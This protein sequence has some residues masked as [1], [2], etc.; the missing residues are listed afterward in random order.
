[1]AGNLSLTREYGR[2]FTIMRDE[3]IDP[4]LWDNVSTRTALL[5]CMKAKGAIIETG[6]R[7]QLAFK[8]LKELPTSVGYSDLETITPVR[9]DPWTQARYLWKQIACPVQVSGLDM[10]QTGEG[11]ESD[12]LE[13]FIQ[14]AEISMRESI[15]GS[16]I[17]IFSSIGDTTLTGISGLQSHFTTSTTTGTVGQLSRAS[18]SNWR[19]QLQNV[20]SAFDSN[21]INLMTQLYYEC[22]RFDETPDIFVV[23]KSTWLNFMRETTR[24][25][26]TNFPMMIGE[27]DKMMI[28][29]GFPNTRHFGALLFG[30][31]GCLANT[32]YCFNTKFVKLYVRSGRNAELGDFVKSQSKDDLAAFV[33]W[34]GELCNTNLARGGLLQNADTY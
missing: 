15:G 25:F 33:F 13:G 9:G 30:D 10:I 23:T 26:S 17:G 7:P 31:D 32:G 3:V 11:N 28:D 24:T 29:A 5:Y 16:S 21:G 22:S 1:M 12:L 27:G 8:I 34:A 20:A 18:Q 2:I 6:G 14:T 19:H 4:Y